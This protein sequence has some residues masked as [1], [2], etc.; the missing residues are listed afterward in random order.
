MIS[1]RVAVIRV[2]SRSFSGLLAH[3]PPPPSTGMTE[4]GDGYSQKG[5]GG[6]LE[7]EGGKGVTGPG[8]PTR[9]ANRMREN[10]NM[11]RIKARPVR[12]LHPV[13]KDGQRC[14]INLQ[15]M[16]I[17][18]GLHTFSRAIKNQ[19]QAE[20]CSRME[21]EAPEIR[22]GGR[23]GKYPGASPKNMNGPVLG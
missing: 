21:N 19:E 13:F 15:K 1:Y 7:S 22:C 16:S 18:S 5:I 2:I 14:S 6:A 11:L 20:A 23:G 9:T 3:T 12:P 10:K 17:N 8:P 4:S